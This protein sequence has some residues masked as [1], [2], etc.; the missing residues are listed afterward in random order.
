MNLRLPLP[1]LAAP[2]AAPTSPHAIFGPQE[3]DRMLTRGEVARFLAVSVTTLERWGAEGSGPECI[4]IGRRKVG[5][6]VRA[7]LGFLDGR[8]VLRAAA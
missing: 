6:P 4:K 1:N 2:V 3:L 7:L 5:Y 8:R